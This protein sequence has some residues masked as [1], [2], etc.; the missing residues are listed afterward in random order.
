MANTLE[1][2]ATWAAGLELSSVP[3]DVMRRVQ[4]QHISTAAA[5]A[6]VHDW[7]QAPSAQHAE[8]TLAGLA[9]HLDNTDHIF[10][11]QTTPGAVC[12]TWAH[13]P[14][15]KA[16]AALVAS[17]V[18]NELGARV[19]LALSLNGQP[20]KSALLL[21][22]FCAAASTARCM[23]L[24]HT[25]SVTAYA[26]AVEEVEKNQPPPSLD[27]AA[28]TRAIDHGITAAERASQGETTS[29]EAL[30][31]MCTAGGTLPLEQTFSG[32]GTCW[33]TRS[34]AYSLNPGHLFSQVPVQAV[35]EILR[36]H[37]KA[38]DK[39]LRVDQIAKIEIKTHALTLALDARAQAEALDSQNVCANIRQQIA[40]LI[41][42]HERDAEQFHPM[43]LAEHSENIRALS[44]K[45]EICHDWAA[46][47]RLTTE[48]RKSL[49]SHY[50]RLSPNDLWQR[51][52]KGSTELGWKPG[53]PPPDQW[54]E[55]L[56]ERPD[57]LFRRQKTFPSL[58]EIDARTLRYVFPTEVKV[59]TTRGGWWPER[60]ETPE[61]APGWSWQA[62]VD[63]VLQKF[64]RSTQTELENAKSLY[65]ALPKGSNKTWTKAL[66]LP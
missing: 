37:I 10:W 53:F 33:L 6:A 58:N 26:I 31:Q 28:I 65:K 66:R 30:N 23:K 21:H 34:L 3:E 35:H 48:M 38:A 5:V 17:V 44:D 29:L 4:L 39:R 47:L 19:G 60:R 7:A 11:G 55:I 12:P 32:L 56:K 63:G 40:L 61:G 45:I 62:T 22:A 24:S 59:Y 54:A 9:C 13:R 52:S 16:D 14:R 15:S 50:A 18:A 36:R 25:Q 8:A 1:D 43:T 64:S 42:T 41:A 51:F 20:A 2:I 46:T 57:K 49:P 27:S